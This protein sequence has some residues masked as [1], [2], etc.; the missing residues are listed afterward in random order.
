MLGNNV[1]I[2]DT[3][4]RDGAQAANI[5]FTLHDKIR[6]ALALDDLGV[7]YIEGGWPGS[8]PKDKEF[9]RQIRQH[10]LRYSKVAAFGSTRKK[11]VKASQDANLNA[12]LDSEVGTAVLFGKSW[13]L[14]VKEILHATP[15][16]NLDIVYDSVSYMKAHGLEVIFDA[17]HFYQGFINNRDYAMQVLDAATRGGART[18]TLCD[19]NGGTPP[20]RIYSITKEVVDRSKAEVGMHT[21]NDTGCAVANAVMGVTAGARHVQGTIN[22]IGERTGNADLMQVLPTLTF[23]LGYNT[24]NKGKLRNLK[25]I[26]SMLYNMTEMHPNL[27][28]PFVGDYAFAHKGGIHADAVRKN[29]A[30]YEHMRPELVGNKRSIVISELSGTSN[31]LDYADKAGLDFDKKD[32][33]VKAALEK[34]KS[35]EG[36]GYSFDLAPASAMLI[37]LK[38]TGLY[39]EYIKLSYWKVISEHDLNIAVLKNKDLT[40]VGKGDGPVN[41]IDTALRRLFYR[42]YPELKKV[43]LTD[44][45]VVLPGSIKNTASVVRVV[46]EFSNGSQSWRTIG[47][48]TNII[49]A[50]VKA[51][52]DG[53]NYYLWVCKAGQ[54]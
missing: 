9:F 33:R 32:K 53:L 40:E 43:L 39:K 10:K 45:R 54:K 5:S 7:G 28:Q 37:L 26:S 1:E 27:Y 38:E 4:L 35:L 22:G 6:I 25:K 23:A 31:L 21:H 49:D 51:L 52:V 29:P 8:N 46:I 47:V 2:L 41:A 14:H 24:V 34:V 19:T 13:L 48:S 12:I 20:P 30:S 44:Y 36:R 50:S 3:T 15:Q 16:E 11:D 42:A 17:E 18:V